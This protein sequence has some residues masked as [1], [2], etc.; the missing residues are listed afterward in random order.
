MTALVGYSSLVTTCQDERHRHTTL[1]GKWTSRATEHCLM[2]D[3]AMPH[4]E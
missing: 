3:G 2:S 4:N 1:G